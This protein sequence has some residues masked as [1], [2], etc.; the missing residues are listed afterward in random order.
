MSKQFGHLLR[1]FKRMLV[2]LSEKMTSPR[3]GST[4]NR[5][6]FLLFLLPYGSSL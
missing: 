2:E 4:F 5:R 3:A 6:G 1:N